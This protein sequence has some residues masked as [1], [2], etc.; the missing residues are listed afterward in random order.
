MK[1]RVPNLEE[2]KIRASLLLKALNGDDGQKKARASERWQR[3]FEVPHHP[4]RKQALQVV[5]L[6]NGFG[7]WAELKAHFEPQ[8]GITLCP[9][10]SAGFLNEWHNS[11]DQASAARQRSDGY[12]LL[13]GRHFFVCSRSYIESV[14]GLDP[15][16]P[17]WERM[18]KDWAR[19]RDPQARE[20]LAQ[21]LPER[22]RV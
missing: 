16:D 3:H 7:S 5:A 6:E 2:F 19:P 22:C 9:R 1:T 15:D 18:G 14:L 12:L 21:S 20:R 17:D 8:T 4:R 11:Y 10:G 13:H